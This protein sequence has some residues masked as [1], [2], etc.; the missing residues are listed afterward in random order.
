METTT[1]FLTLTSAGISLTG[2]DTAKLAL[3]STR[4]RFIYTR[5]LPSV[6]VHEQPP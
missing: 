1:L 4:I 2:T 3:T 6:R 5:C